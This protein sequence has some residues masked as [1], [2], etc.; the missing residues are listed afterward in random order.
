[1]QEDEDLLIKGQES[2]TLTYNQMNII[3]YRMGEKQMLK[4]LIDFCEKVLH[5][6]RNDSMYEILDGVQKLLKEKTIYTA[7]LADPG[8]LRLFKPKSTKIYGEER[9]L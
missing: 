6:F 2:K 1:M 3:K 8:F 5:V 7:Y 9:D 4:A